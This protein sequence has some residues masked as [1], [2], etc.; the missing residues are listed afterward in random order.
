MQ[1]GEN[2]ILFGMSRLRKNI[3]RGVL[4]RIGQGSVLR[5]GRPI[6]SRFFDRRALGGDTRRDRLTL[7]AG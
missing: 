3:E 4:T 5:S 7:C 2:F 1:N 6:E